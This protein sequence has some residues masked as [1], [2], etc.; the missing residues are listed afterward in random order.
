MYSRPPPLKQANI[1]LFLIR[2][3]LLD[4]VTHYIFGPDWTNNSTEMQIISRIQPFSVVV[5][6]PVCLSQGRFSLYSN[7][8]KTVDR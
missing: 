5:R 4:F 3:G 2:Y 1:C 7:M 6:L 8:I